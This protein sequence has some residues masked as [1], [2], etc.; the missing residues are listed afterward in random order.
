MSLCHPSEAFKD[1]V[2]CIHLIALSTH[3]IPFSVCCAP[4]LWAARTYMSLSQI[5]VWFL[6]P[7][8]CSCWFCFVLFL[9][10]SGS[11][12]VSFCV[13]LWPLKSCWSAVSETPSCLTL[14]LAE[15]NHF[16]LCRPRTCASMN[17]YDCMHP[18][19]LEGLGFLYGF[20]SR[21]WAVLSKCTDIISVQHKLVPNKC[22]LNDSGRKK[23]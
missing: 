5:V 15:K 21:L 12:A 14:P 4:A 10:F 9:S 6:L 1:L 11:N 13:L 18:T 23:W 17:F 16:F 20:S 19:W 2:A 8:L 22:L 3:S 7:C